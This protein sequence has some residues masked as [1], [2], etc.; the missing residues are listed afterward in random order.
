MTSLRPPTHI[1][2]SYRRRRYCKGLKAKLQV[3]AK[4]QRPSP[5]AKL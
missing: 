5:R 2:T 4:A 3:E 1:S